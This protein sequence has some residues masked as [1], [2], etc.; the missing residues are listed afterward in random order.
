MLHVDV[1]YQLPFTSSVE[2]GLAEF[3][4]ALKEAWQECGMYL[5]DNFVAKHFT[6]EGAAEY[7]FA[8]RAGEDTG[9]KNFWR[10]YTGRKQKKY[11]HTLAGVL[12]GR[13]KEGARRAT[14]YATGKGVRV[15]LPGCV[16]LNQY[17]PR[18]KRLG[19]HAGEPPIDLRDELMTIAPSEAETIRKI[20]DASIRRQFGARVG[21]A[22]KQMKRIEP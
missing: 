8:P 21:W 11:H 22:D 3:R 7:H 15:A 20:H 6:K 16:H 4:R 18:P 10:S 19:P 1:R 9:G 14:I 5:F 12:T 2:L 13:T 17:K